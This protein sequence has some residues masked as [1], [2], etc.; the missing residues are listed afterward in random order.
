MTIVDNDTAAPA[1]SI[2]DARIA[3]GNSGTKLL[4]FPVSLT[5]NGFG[6]AISVRYKTINGSATSGSD[7]VAVTAGTLIIAAGQ[8]SGVINI[9]I[10]GD[11]TV[12]A[13]E[14]FSL[15]IAL[16]APANTKLVRAM[17]TGTILNDDAA[18]TKINTATTVTSSLNPSQFGQRVTFTVRVRTASGSII[19]A[20]IVTLKDGTT[21]LG[22]GALNAQ[23]M[24]ALTTSRLSVGTHR[25]TASYAGNA[26]FNGSASAPLN[27]VV[28]AAP[29]LPMLS[30]NDVT[31]PEGNSGTRNF[32]FT[33]TLSRAS[34]QTVTVRYATGNGSAT[35]GAKITR[36]L[37]AR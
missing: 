19:P 15:M 2:G 35:G 23:G 37:R 17:A 11:T 34:T 6:S 27:Q 32:V 9:T 18:P 24:A 33:V 3:E 36:R 26:N 5:R 13:N 28:R 25:I 4:A 20:G 21:T 14:T 1:L 29:V 8:N 12:E 31:L 22:S 7:Y 16:P 10:N 30:I